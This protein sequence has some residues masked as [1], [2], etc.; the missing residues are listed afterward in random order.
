MLSADFW[1]KYFEVYDVLNLLIPY[2][3]LLNT[4][5]DELDVKEGDK[6]LEA[7]CGTC[8]LALKLEERG[9][10]VVGLDNS[11]AALDICRSKNPV[12][13][14]VLSDLREKLPFPNEHFDKITCNNVLY[15]I[16]KKKHKEV[17]KEFIR[18]LKPNGKVVIANP[19]KGWSPFKIYLEGLKLNFKEQGF[20]K[21]LVKVTLLIK[22]AIKILYYNHF[23]TQENEYYFFEKGEQKVLLQEVG[24]SDVSNDFSVYADQSILNSGR[25]L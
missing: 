18:V 11:Q 5:C 14:L 2:Q 23:I 21:S 19:K 3:K 25:K 20:L 24:F 12:L 4:I 8:N 17:L 6:V 10:E 13:E 9:A 15:A 22:P 16:P 7:G 1:R